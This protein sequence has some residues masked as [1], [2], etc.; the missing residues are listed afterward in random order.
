MD[1]IEALG[2]RPNDISSYLD[3]G[4]FGVL[5]ADF[6]AEGHSIGTYTPK[7]SYYA[8][9]NIASIFA[10]D[11]ENYD[12]PVIAIPQ[13]APET[14]AMDLKFKELT[15]GAFKRDGGELFAYWNPTNIMTTSYMGTAS[16]EI[17]SKYKSVRLIDAMSGEIY[18][19]PAEIVKRDE[20]GMFS[21]THLPVKDT[22]LLLE[23]GNF[24]KE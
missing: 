3:Y 20:Y 18:E 9:Q 16:F 7:P 14:Y 24:I 17:Y 11:F 2:G 15:L 12:I 5:G 23:F 4:Y 19:I 8:L 13:Y 6:D 1:M 10:E 21:F 22:P